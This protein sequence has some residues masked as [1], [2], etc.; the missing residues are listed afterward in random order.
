MSDAAASTRFAGPSAHRRRSAS[1]CV[2]QGV[3]F[4]ASHRA[5]LRRRHRSPALRKDP[6]MWLSTP[7]PA[8]KSSAFKSP[9]RSPLACARPSFRCIIEA[10]IRLADH[11][12]P[13]FGGC[14]VR[15]AV[16]FV[17]SDALQ[18]AIT[19]RAVEDKM[20]DDAACGQSLGINRSARA[21]NAPSRVAAS[22]QKGEGGHGE[23]GNSKAESRDLESGAP[24]G[25]KA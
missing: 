25:A 11:R 15:M 12:S 21:K 24:M 16:R 8:R 5:D 9:I 13:D 22:G 20:F 23:M 3:R 19:R 7:S 1:T 14:S 10:A 6:V 17:F 18:G 2:E 4:V